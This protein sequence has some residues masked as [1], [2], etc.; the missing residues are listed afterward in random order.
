MKMENSFFYY[1]SYMDVTRCVT[2]S[3]DGVNMVVS[4]L[5]FPVSMQAFSCF[6][7]EE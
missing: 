5:L 3:I 7:R 2:L 6:R 1:W 4:M